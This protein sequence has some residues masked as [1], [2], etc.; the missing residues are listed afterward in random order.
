MAQQN[1]KKVLLV[2]D[3]LD[4][5]AVLNRVIFSI[6]PA[7]ILDWCTSAEE[8]VQIVG[9]DYDLI[10]ADVYLD[11]EKSGLELWRICQKKNVNA[12]IIFTSATNRE[13]VFQHSPIIERSCLFIQKPFA[14]EDCRALIV[15]TL[16]P[17]LEGTSL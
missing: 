4:L 13:K 15:Q 10:I 8:A 5:S 16:F 3:D 12:K 14:I 6:D 11:G 2:E 7:I 17:E 9:S 1:P